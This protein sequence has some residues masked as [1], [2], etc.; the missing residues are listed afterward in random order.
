METVTAPPT[1]LMMEPVAPKKAAKKTPNEMQEPMHF[2]EPVVPSGNANL[3]ELP[4]K[5]KFGYPTHLE[6]RDIMVKDEEIL[7]SATTSTY[8]K[9]FNGVLK[10][11]LNDC[12]F[13]E[14]MTTY[15]RDYALIWV[16]ANN[17]GA[18][19]KIQIA[20]GN[21]KCKKEHVHNVDMTKLP[22]VDIKD[23]LKT[24]YFFNLKK[25]GQPVSIR[26]YTVEDELVSE[27]YVKSNPDERHS[28]VMLVRSLDIGHDLPLELKIRWVKENVTGHEMARIRK[29][30]STF[31]YGV[32]TTLDYEC[33]ACGEVTQG[34]IPFQA[35][36]ILY[37]ALSADIEEFV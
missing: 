18:N 13:Y 1:A 36:D 8:A 11:V 3:L 14:K 12:P 7:A 26:L 30:H 20:C 24:P 34:D 31:A 37:P 21:P 28:T 33:P 25:T 22:I 29:Y 16:W 32:S 35:A 6:Y 17:Y 19:K 15:D 4:S 23:N 5:G 27:E 2:E 9:T 10:S